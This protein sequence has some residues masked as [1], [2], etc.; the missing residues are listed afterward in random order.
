V[1]QH[2]RLRDA[3]TTGVGGQFVFSLT[4]IFMGLLWQTTE[5]DIWVR[6]LCWAAVVA[7]AGCAIYFGSRLLRREDAKATRPGE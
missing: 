6:V 5:L 7:G 2:V 4:L 3:S 1:H